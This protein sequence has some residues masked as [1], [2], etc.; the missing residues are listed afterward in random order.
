MDFSQRKESSKEE[1]ES[2]QKCFK[3]GGENVREMWI[4]SPFSGVETPASRDRAPEDSGD[5][6]GMGAWGP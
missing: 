2:V 1:I 4:A 6:T 5:F 3:P